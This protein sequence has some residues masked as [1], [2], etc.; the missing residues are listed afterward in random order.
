MTSK[1]SLRS[2]FVALAAAFC[3][4]GGTTAQGLPPTVEADR[5]LQLGAAEMAKGEKGDAAAWAKAAAALKGAEATGVRMPD[6]F[7]YHYG[8]A[9]H[10][11]G[12]H[13][14]AHERLER[15]LRTHGTKGKYYSEALAQYTSV[16]NALA[17]ARVAADKQAVVDR[18]WRWVRSTWVHAGDEGTDCYKATRRVKSQSSS[19]REIDCDCDVKDNDH[20]AYR[21]SLLTICKIR[22]QGNTVLDKASSFYLDREYSSRRQDFETFKSSEE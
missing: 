15:Y 3:L 21:G 7:D 20:P 19:A 22:W 4:H 11:V 16:Q 2:M 1:T 5:L 13:T 17:E 6:N 18:G 10:A 8:R 9:S 12:Q 14:V